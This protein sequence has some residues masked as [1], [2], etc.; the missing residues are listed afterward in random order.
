MPFILNSGYQ[1]RPW[2][3][4]NSHFETIIPSVFNKVEGVVYQKDRLELD[5]GDFLD[6]DWLRNESNRVMILSHGME[7]S[8]Q[9]HYIK[10]SAKYFHAKGWDI[11]AWNNRGCGGEMN[12]LPRLYHHGETEDLA[13]VINYAEGLGYDQ[14][15]LLGI[16]MGGCQTV[17]YLGEKEVNKKV[18]GGFGVSVSCNL[19]DTTDAAAHNLGGFYQ[20]RFL[21][22]LKERVRQKVLEHKVL[23][24]IN[25]DAID[26]FNDFHEKVTCLLYDFKDSN[27]FYER[28]SSLEYFDSI[29]TP[30]FILNALNDPL[31]G[32]R[33][34]PIEKAKNHQFI[35]L[36][37]PKFGGHVGFT[38]PGKEY[39]YIEQSV[40]RFLNEVIQLSET[41]AKQS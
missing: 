7:G 9:R 18:I 23:G 34:Y 35:Y 26:N 39:S 40:E 1:R 10:R 14:I 36:E 24:D 13:Q 28:G 12:R 5:D 16:S 37:T 27:D 30:V 3:F 22:K 2:Y 31:L 11:L 21:G 8:S 25:L 6:L 19:K 29:Q 41:S 15:F 32:P 17:K 33:C 20:K 38:I 4:F